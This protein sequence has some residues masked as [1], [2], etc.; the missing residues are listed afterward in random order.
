MSAIYLPTYLAL[1]CYILPIV[2]TSIDAYKSLV[3]DFE[4]A[5]FRQ[6]SD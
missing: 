1:A 3:E 2:E 5:A 6:I 4:V